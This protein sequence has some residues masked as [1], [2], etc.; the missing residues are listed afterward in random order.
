MEGITRLLE[1]IMRLAV[2][3]VLWVL[4]SLPVVF[5]TLPVFFADNASAVFTN[6]LIIAMLAPFFFFPATTAMFGVV[7][8]WIFGDADVPLFQTYWKSYKQNYAKS[9]KSGIILTIIWLIV[10]ID[11]YYFSNVNLFIGGFFLI[12]SFF[13]FNL[14]IY[15]FANSVHTDLKIFA[16]IKNSFLLSIINP[17]YNLCIFVINATIIYISFF[18]FTGFIPF[19]IGTM[20]SFV[21]LKG[22][23]QKLKLVEKL[24]ERV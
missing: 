3:N 15:Y 12:G 8:H 2:I 1:W 4:F 11:I 18:V 16:L 14:T 23:Q 5:V 6:L 19:F 9:L 17:V 24:K 21:T 22:Y 10:G 7:H 13:L 20:I